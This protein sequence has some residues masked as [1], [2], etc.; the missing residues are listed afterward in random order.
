MKMHSCPENSRHQAEVGRHR[1]SFDLVFGATGMKILEEPLL[2]FDH[3]KTL[4][5][6]VFP[7][8]DAAESTCY[9]LRDQVV[10]RVWGMLPFSDSGLHRLLYLPFT[11]AVS[12]HTRE[13]RVQLQEAHRLWREAETL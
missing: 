11:Y 9:Y 4:L 2:S 6:S 8:A 3:F 13:S 12:L 10:E 1:Y 7:N 5:F